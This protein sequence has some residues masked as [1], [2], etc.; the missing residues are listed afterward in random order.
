MEQDYR[1]DEKIDNMGGKPEELGVM[2]TNTVSCAGLE[3]TG[4]GSCGI[5]NDLSTLRFTK[6][7]SQYRH[8]LPWY[9]QVLL[10]NEKDQP[11]P[12]KTIFVT[13][14]EA[15]Y[16][17]SATTDEHGFVNI[18]LDTTNYTSPSITVSVKYK[19]NDNRFDNWRVREFHAQALYVAKHFVSP[20]NSYVHLKPILGTLTCGQTQE[21]QAHYLLNKQILKDEKKFTFYY[22]IEARGSIAQSGMH[23]LSIKQGNTEGVFSFSFQVESVLAPRA[24][25]LVY[26]ILPNG[27]I[28]ADI[29][30]FAVENCFANKVN[31]RFSSAQSLPAS[32]NRLKVTATPFSLCALRAVD[33]SVL[34][35]KPEAELSPRSVSPISTL[36]IMKCSHDKI[37]FGS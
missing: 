19:D 6:A 28:V 9:G 34:L 30:K 10:V 32:D 16:H 25:L 27:E 22:L 36:G 37:T 24:H 1:G 23:V 20:S 31:L 26:T 12:N 17:S 14:E 13:V 3:L 5:A 21:I 18:S 8:G 15:R 11:I 35:M 29:D 4:Y 2:G 33:R 7:D